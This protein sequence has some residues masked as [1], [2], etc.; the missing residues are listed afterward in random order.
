MYQFMWRHLLLFLSALFLGNCGGKSDTYDF[1]IALDPIWYSLEAP[2]R[3]TALTAFTIEL[4]A[5]IGKVEKLTFGLYQKSWND[6]IY[7]LQQKNYDAI[8]STMQPYLF[9]D[10]M[11]A[12]SHLYLMTG[13]VLVVPAALPSSSL[14]QL[15][16]KIVGIIR[17]SNSALILEKYPQIIQRTYSSI[18]EVLL[19]VSTQTVDAAV[20]NLLAA[21]AFTQNLF[22]NRLKIGSPPLTQEGVRLISLKGKSESLIFR[23]NRGL[24]KLHENGTYATLAKKW[25]LA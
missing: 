25:Q 21:E 13:P 12:F 1:K 11:Y 23:F 17:D 7:G 19:D 5:E 22:H 8:C 20:I 2:G 9:F 14:A 16:G 10:Q 6:L 24:K 3:E 18:P 4:I 15:D